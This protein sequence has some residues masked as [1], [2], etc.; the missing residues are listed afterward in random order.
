M[1]RLLT[2]SDDDVAEAVGVLQRGG[3]VAFPTETV[4]GLGA[5]ARDRGALARLYAAKGRP[6]S[7]PVIVHLPSAEAL[8]G[9]AREIPE[10]ARRL[11]EAFWPGPL[12]LVL[13]RAAGVPDEVTGGQDT[14]GLRVPDHPLALRLLHRFGDG[15]AAPSAN[16]FGRISPTTA[17]HVAD[18]FADLDVLVLDGGPCRV[19]LESTIVDLS[20][21]AP[22]LLRPGGVHRHALEQLLGERVALAEHLSERDE[23]RPERPA[24][25]PAG[26]AG[27][28]TPVPR[29]PGGLP[30]HYAPTTPAELVAPE[31]LEARV[32]QLGAAVAVLARRPPPPE[33]RG[34]WTELPGDPESYAQALYAALRRLDA[35]GS[36]R[37]VIEAVPA[38]PDWLAVRD[39]LHRATAADRTGLAPDREEGP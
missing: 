16:R 20:A 26:A 10:R 30:R 22:R 13:Q 23:P 31:A 3:L 12:T 21:G 11:A 7:H 33:Y 36:A 34:A 24:E 17:A 29:A 8:P 2:P 15:V 25:G 5:A 28:Q 1:S 6:P 18:E 32:R 19:G 9:W 37:I 4:Y 39:R 38:G 27:A 35:S 14:V